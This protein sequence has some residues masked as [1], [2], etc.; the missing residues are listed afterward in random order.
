MRRRPA[1]KRPCAVGVNTSTGER[2]PHPVSTQVANAKPLEGTLDASYYGPAC[3]QV[4]TNTSTYGVEHG[5]HVL[6]VWRPAGVAEDV[7]LPVLLYVPG[8][9][10]DYGEAE[11]Y[12]ATFLAAEHAAVVASINYRVGPFGFLAFSEDAGARAFRS[13]SSVQPRKR[14]RP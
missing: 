1:S 3:L 12:N 7:K 2:R 4:L 14:R 8:G 9:E 11:P 13:A 5:C 10:N 6:N